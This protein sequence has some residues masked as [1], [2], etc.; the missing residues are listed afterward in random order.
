MFL[1]SFFA[2]SPLQDVDR[3][4]AITHKQ[5]QFECHTFR[6]H[7]IATTSKGTSLAVYDMRYKSRQ[8]LHEQMD[9]GLS[10]LTDDGDTWARSGTIIHMKKFGGL[11]EDQN[12]CS[13][14]NILIDRKTGEILASAVWTHGKSNTQQ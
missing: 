11:P 12:R 8:D 3:K 5:G 4:F 10:R 9:I 2:F 7:T 14:P 13:D 6:T 1:L